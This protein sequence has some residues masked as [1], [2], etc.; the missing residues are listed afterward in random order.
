MTFWE[1]WQQKKRPTVSFE[2][3]PAR[4]EDAA[5]KLHRV[6]DDLS[7]LKPDFV[8]VT[9]GAGGS[10]SE[11]SYQLA[12]HLA[13][14]NKLPVVTYL[15]GIGLTRNQVQDI[16]IRYKN[17]GIQSVL[18]VRGDQAKDE[19]T[20]VQSGDFTNA[21]DLLEFV[22]TNFDFRLGAAGYPE[23]HSE[24]QDKETDWDFLKLKTEKGAQFIISQYFYDNEYFFNFMNQCRSRDINTPIIA[25]IMPI[26]SVNMMETLAE[27]CGT[28][29]TKRI[30]DGLANI[31]PE[32]K[33]AVEIF[34][35][36]FALQQCG[37]LLENGVDGLHFYTMDRSQSVGR[38]IAQL[39]QAGWLHNE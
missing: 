14:E 2:F 28:T 1:L 6:I 10:T 22:K 5:E 25:G 17:I 13:V 15:A 7:L 9:F 35:I 19:Q 4:N 21:S 38:I 26:Y 36:E 20:P 31:D 34:G 37:E 24:S 27:L 3:F 16:L 30:R 23:G 12:K 32:D 39:K 11:G 29:I 18:C 33:N 8:S